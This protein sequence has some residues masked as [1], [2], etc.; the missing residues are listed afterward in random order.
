MN[1]K[2][3]TMFVATLAT[4]LAF[5]GCKKNK[6]ISVPATETVGEVVVTTA[7]TEENVTLATVE[8]PFDPQLDDDWEEQTT[9]PKETK[10]KETQPKETQPKETQPKETQPKETQPKETQPKETQPKETEPKETKPKDPLALEYEAYL[11]M[12]PTQQQEKYE[13]MGAAAFMDWLQRAKIAYKNSLEYV[14][15]SDGVIDLGELG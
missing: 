7:A 5:T 13:Q 3:M 1:R 10:P 2:T 6:E 12:T 11:N 15:I 9:E 14:D 8:V 4:V